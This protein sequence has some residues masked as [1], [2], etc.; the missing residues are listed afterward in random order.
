MYKTPSGKTANTVLLM[1]VMYLNFFV[2]EF[3]WENIDET[4]LHYF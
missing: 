3:L 1:D 2:F 4:T